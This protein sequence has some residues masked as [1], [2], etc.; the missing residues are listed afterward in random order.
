[1]SMLIV[2]GKVG[3][4]VTDALLAS[5]SFAATANASGISYEN[6]E[7]S[8][9][10]LPELLLPVLVGVIVPFFKQLLFNWAKKAKERKLAR[11]SQ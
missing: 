2:K 9:S 1:M 6:V 4:V 8:G 11:N 5:G 3:S 10:T 7:P